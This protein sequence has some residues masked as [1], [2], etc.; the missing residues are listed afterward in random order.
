MNGT[1]TRA[2]REHVEWLP[3]VGWEGLY[4][5]SRIGLVRS[6]PRTGVIRNGGI[7]SYGG[8]PVRPIVGTRGYLVVNLTRAGKRQQ[9]FLHR[10]VLEAFVGPRPASYDACHWNGDRLDARLENLRWDSKRNNCADKLRHGTAQ[11]GERG[12]RAKLTEA[13]VR[14][15]RASGLGPAAVQRAFGLSRTNAKHIVSGETWKHIT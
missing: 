2:E 4:E 10:L 13:T 1:Y 9:V 5:V 12:S 3:V 6:L 15:I 14:A 11:I 7:R 8:G